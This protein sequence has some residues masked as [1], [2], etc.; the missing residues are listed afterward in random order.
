M[1]STE[2]R[3]LTRV[4]GRDVRYSVFTPLD[5]EAREVLWWIVGEPHDLF[6]EGVAFAEG[7][8]VW[9]REEGNNADYVYQALLNAGIEMCWPSGESLRLSQEA[10][11]AYDKLCQDLASAQRIHLFTIAQ[12][13]GWSRSQL[14]AHLLT[15]YGLHSTS[16][17][18]GQ[19]YDRVMEDLDG[20]P[21]PT[22]S[23][24][25]GSTVLMPMATD[26]LASQWIEDVFGHAMNQKAKRQSRRTSSDRA[27][28][29]R[30]LCLHESCGSLGLF[31]VIA[32]R[33]EITDAAVVT[34]ADAGASRQA[35]QE[36]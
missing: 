28:R 21:P 7:H 29:G 20:G 30:R 16:E 17:I 15:K 25:D 36:A 10:L 27:A 5:E 11:D 31:D 32:I 12:E 2:S 13:K 24:A 4:V 22:P 26:A 18:A 23:D 1:R 33:S 35:G 19:V 3:V 9:V 14:E 34:C 8:A 6:E